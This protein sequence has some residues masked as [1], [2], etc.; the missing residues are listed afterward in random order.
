M[1]SKIF[2]LIPFIL[3]ALLGCSSDK[4][5]GAAPVDFC[6]QA[7]VKD[8]NQVIK[9]ISTTEELW[10]SRQTRIPSYW[11]KDI[12][13]LDR[14]CQKFYAQHAQIRCM[15]DIEDE[16]LLI[17]S[18]NL[19]SYCQTADELAVEYKDVREAPEAF[20]DDFSEDLPFE[21]DTEEMEDEDFEER[22]PEVVDEEAIEEQDDKSPSSDEIEL[23]PVPNAGKVPNGTLPP[24]KTPSEK[25]SAPATELPASTAIQDVPAARIKITVK[26]TSAVQKLLESREVV[27]SEGVIDSLQSPKILEKVQKGLAFCSLTSIEKEMWIDNLSDAMKL[28]V[29]S[30]S[31]SKEDMQSF[32]QITITLEDERT[33]INLS[34]LKR[35]QEP[36]SVAEITKALSGALVIDIK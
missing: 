21:E 30:I 4:K 7:F 26:K 22:F 27:I 15:A 5:A 35:S 23:L 3:M 14:S 16:T 2:F 13:I 1:T 34:C 11:M 36:F 29:K 32:Q 19:A 28:S 31:Q 25:E 9:G 10:S 8:Y 6:T 24:L 18:Q 20:S 12:L 33:G 17:T